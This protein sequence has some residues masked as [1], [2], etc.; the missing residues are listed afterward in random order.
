MIYVLFLLGKISTKEIAIDPR[1][2]KNPSAEAQ[3]IAQNVAFQLENTFQFNHCNRGFR[4][5]MCYIA[6]KLFFNHQFT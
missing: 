2:I 4:E 5:K 3:L 1:E 6:D